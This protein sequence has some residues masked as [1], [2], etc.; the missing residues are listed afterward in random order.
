MAYFSQRVVSK[1]QALFTKISYSCCSNEQCIATRVHYLLFSA[2]NS[3]KIVQE[4]HN[5][6]VVAG[7]TAKFTVSVGGRP[8]PSIRWYK[9]ETEI[10]QG[11]KKKRSLRLM[12]S[13]CTLKPLWGVVNSNALLLQDLP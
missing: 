11:K 8:Y 7:Q 9:N 1:N 4:L 13:T 6:S 3:P 10:P 5:C 2:L 12:K